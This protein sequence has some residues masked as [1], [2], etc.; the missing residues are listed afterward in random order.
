M[1]VR[2][3]S[4]EAL[5]SVASMVVTPLSFMLWSSVSQFEISI[6]LQMTLAMCT[7]VYASVA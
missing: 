1:I 3:K 4:E 2:Q 7:S 5:A 6:H